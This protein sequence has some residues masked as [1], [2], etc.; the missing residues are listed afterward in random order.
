MMML[1]V[2]QSTRL[3]PNHE[4]KRIMRP[5]DLFLSAALAAIAWTPSLSQSNP[6]ST[7]RF[8]IIGGAN[9]ATL[10]GSFGQN[11]SNR[12]G[13]AGGLMAVLPV[14][15]SFAI[16]P[17]L[18]F[19]MKGKNTKLGRTSATSKIDYIELPVLARFEIPAFGRVKPF[20]YGG[21]GFAYRTSC[22]LGRIVVTTN[23]EGVITSLEATSTDCDSS[24]RQAALAVPGAK[25]SSTDVDGIIG[26][27][28]AFDVGGRTMTVGVRYDVG[29]VK[30]YRYS[31]SK[32][33]ALSFMGTL[34]WP[35]H[36]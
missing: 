20:V 26:G 23:A 35:F 25:F 11:A 2:R 16:Q 8:G 27:G 28:L 22:T 17:E 19:T 30:F 4:A 34:E 32:N 21:P 31:D 18:M 29:F 12:I 36:K 9:L 6:Q 1:G 33:R 10:T 24:A 5:R 7:P 15:S 13:F 14:S 3:S